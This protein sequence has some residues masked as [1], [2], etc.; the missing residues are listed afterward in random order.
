MVLGGLVKKLII[1]LTPPF[2]QK[3]YAKICAFYSL[4]IAF[5][6]SIPGKLKKFGIIGFKASKKTIATYPIKEKISEWQKVLQEEAKRKKNDGIVG[7]LTRPFIL[8]GLYLKNWLDS[9][10]P[11]HVVLLF[12]FTVGSILS[13]MLVVENSKKIALLE[14]GGAR[15][16]ASV[17]EEKIKRPVYYKK[18]TRDFEI[19]A[20]KI[21]VYFADLNEYR[22][23][24]VD[25]SIILT[26]RNSKLYLA[27]NEQ[28]LRDHIIMNVEP[29]I[30]AFNLQSEGKE[31]IRE[32]L[33]YEVSEF[34][35][36]NNVEGS[37]EEVKIIY[38]LAH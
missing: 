9:L 11:G 31:I 22:S 8:L 19:M 10:S 12:V 18:Q 32:K 20:V 3:I 37:V 7:K 21:P 1:K 38:L 27:D 5:I 24:M 34:L 29:T 15:A 33:K 2:I 4:C 36:L 6:G 35:K 13:T 28:I 14:D 16:P 26:N 30:A 25:F 23:V 17:E